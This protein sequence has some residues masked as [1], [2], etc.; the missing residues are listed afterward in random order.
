MANFE[1]SLPF[2]CSLGE[3]SYAFSISEKGL[4]N[5]YRS[6]YALVKSNSALHLKTTGAIFHAMASLLLCN[7]Y[8]P[9][10]NSLWKS[11]RYVI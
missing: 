2:Y 1:G 8:V 5:N 9:L 3:R 7:L 6:I 10:T 4:M 11:I